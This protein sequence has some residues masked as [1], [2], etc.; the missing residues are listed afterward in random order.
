VY[1]IASKGDEMNDIEK[2][3]HELEVAESQVLLAKAK[4]KMAQESARSGYWV[5]IGD[6]YYF[7]LTS[8]KHSPIPNHYTYNCVDLSGYT[9]N[10]IAA[11]N[12]TLIVRR[13]GQVKAGDLVE[14]SHGGFTTSFA[15]YEN[16]TGRS[17]PSEAIQHFLKAINPDT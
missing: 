16:F 13:K 11:E 14:A 7:I 5:K 2:L 10:L 8:K 12:D 6:L 1:P 15:D 3:E 4:L 17:V 9:D